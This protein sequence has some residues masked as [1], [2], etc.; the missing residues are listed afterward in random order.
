M[1]QWDFQLVNRIN[2][3]GLAT[4]ISEIWLLRRKHISPA[5]LSVRLTRMHFYISIVGYRIL[6]YGYANKVS[7]K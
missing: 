7:S 2:V 5:Y 4:A 1:R 3:L 6:Q